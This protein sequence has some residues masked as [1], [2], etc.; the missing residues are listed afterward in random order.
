MTKPGSSLERCVFRPEIVK[1]PLAV[2]SAEDLQKQRESQNLLDWLEAMRRPESPEEVAADQERY[3][4]HTMRELLLRR[5]TRSGEPPPIN[6]TGMERLVQMFWG[7][8]LLEMSVVFIAGKQRFAEVVPVELTPDFVRGRTSL[9]TEHAL[10]VM[11]VSS[12]YWAQANEGIDPF[13]IDPLEARSKASDIVWA[14]RLNPKGLNFVEG[15]WATDNLKEALDDYHGKYPGDD[16]YATKAARE[17]LRNHPVKVPPLLKRWLTRP[18]SLLRHFRIQSMI[19][20]DV[21]LSDLR[22]TEEDRPRFISFY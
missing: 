8:E 10:Y 11:C 3:F 4:E 18:V 2:P 9:A 14:F 16:S 21:I 19:P 7:H 13:G 20:P 15:D 17:V 5:P 12:L 6:V 1:F 22:L